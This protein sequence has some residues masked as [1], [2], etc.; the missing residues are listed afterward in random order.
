[1]S[2][3]RTHHTTH[4]LVAPG[5]EDVAQVGA[6]QHVVSTRHHCRGVDPRFSNWLHNNNGVEA[7][8]AASHA[9][10]APVVMGGGVAPA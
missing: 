2:G 1:M 7:G 6:L 5:G 4:G 9:P 8:S 10:A 3:A